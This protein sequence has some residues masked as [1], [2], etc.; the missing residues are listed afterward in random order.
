MGQIL[1]SSATTTHTIRALIQQSKVMLKGLASRYGL[2]HK[3]VA[4]WRKSAFIH[5]APMGP[6]APRATVLTAEED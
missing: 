1:Y 6:N 5:D 2:N 3:T 4:K